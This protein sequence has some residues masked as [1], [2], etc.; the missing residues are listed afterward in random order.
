[1][2]VPG[3]PDAPP[4]PWFFA[5]SKAH[6]LREIQFF[7]NPRSLFGIQAAVLLAASA[8]ACRCA[9]PA[10]LSNV[11]HCLLGFFMIK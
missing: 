5:S 2:N 1:M 7:W 9:T 10:A 8:P 6:L 4:L 11:D 3:M